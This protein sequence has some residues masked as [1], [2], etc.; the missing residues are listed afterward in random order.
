MNSLLHVSLLFISLLIG[1]D[2]FAQL[3]SGPMLG[4]VELRTAYIWCE[5]H[6]KTK[7]TLEYWNVNERQ[8]IHSIKP[9]VTEK[10]GFR[11]LEFYLTDL[12][13]GTEY[14]Y[15]ILVNKKQRPEAYKG[16]FTTQVLWN[17][18]MP[19]PDFSFLAGSCSFFNETPFDRPGKPY[20]G[21]FSIFESMAKENAA[22]MIWLGDNWYYREVDYHSN[23]GLWYRPSRDRRMPVLQNFLKSMSHYAIWDDHD[24]GPNNSNVAYP[25]KH[26]AKHVFETFWCNPGR[27][28]SREGI[29]TQFTYNDVDFF[30]MDCRSFR[31]SD[32]FNDSINGLPNPDKVMWGATQMN[33]LKNQ[34]SSSNA[35]F[36]IIVNGSPILNFYNKYDCLVHFVHEFNELM[37][38]ID[39][40][41]ISGVLFLTGDR[42][43]SEICSYPLKNSY[44]TYEILSSSLTAGIYK[45]TEFE[46]TNPDLV[47]DMLVEQNNYVKITVSGPAKMRKL[48][49]TFKDI[50]GNNIKEWEIEETQLKSK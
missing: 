25:L 40:E 1:Y 2:A 3:K 17:Y 20:G 49:V 35:P 14:Q 24:Y 7:L 31:T 47:L 38:F 8:T 44:R 42:H 36:K 19:A 9:K 10:F 18:R 15:Q 39:L 43:H 23:F 33:W 48:Q 13:P 16:S 32:R 28:P 41:K 30:L 4:P 21:D 27:N 12:K 26:E 37:Q 29:Y 6:P 22:F 45:L 50:R 34:L 5:V 11:I 46:K